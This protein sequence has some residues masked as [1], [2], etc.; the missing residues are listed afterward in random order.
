MTLEYTGRQ[1]W[2]QAE[3]T[4]LLEYM[5]MLL[6]D[7]CIDFW[8]DCGQLLGAMRNGRAVPWDY[9]ADISCFESDIKKIEALSYTIKTDG[10]N[11]TSIKRGQRTHVFKIWKQNPDFHLDIWPCF[12]DEQSI[13]RNIHIGFFHVP[14]ID[15]THMQSIMYEGVDYPCPDNTLQLIESRYGKDWKTYFEVMASSIKL[16]KKYDPTNLEIINYIQDNKLV[17]K[18]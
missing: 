3:V 10:Y 9:D 6:W 17:I 7:N 13:V 18:Q 14:L 1:L 15:L 11:S 2:Y 8:L 16:M 5:T 4:E 12:I